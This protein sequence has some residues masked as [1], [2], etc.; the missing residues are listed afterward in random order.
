[1]ESPPARAP[2][3]RGH[4]DAGGRAAVGRFASSP[5]RP[6]GVRARARS[7]ARARCPD[8]PDA[9]RA[10]RGGSARRP[11]P[12]PRRRAPGRGRAPRS[13]PG[14]RPTLD[15]AVAVAQRVLDQRVEHPVEVGER[16]DAGAPR[17]PR[18]RTA[19][20]APSQ[21]AAA[22]RTAVARDRR[23]AAARRPRRPGRARAARRRSRRAGR[24]R[25]SRRRSPRG[26]S[27]VVAG[28]PRLLEPEPQAA[29]RRAQLV[30]GVG[31]EVALAGDEALEPRRSCR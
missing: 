17:P 4:G 31:H 18:R 7:P 10:C 6:S 19:R 9:P 28:R 26:P 22:R 21:R 23:A 15:L 25:A 12:A 13:A 14:R 2:R 8:G 20:S 3:R 30:R 1:M 27:R 11:P 5:R 24:A 16:A 29:Q